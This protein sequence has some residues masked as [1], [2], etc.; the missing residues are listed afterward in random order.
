[1]REQRLKRFSEVVGRIVPDA[2][3]ASIVL[4][5]LLAG[6]AIAM[7]NSL[8]ATMD[9]YYRGLWMLL[10][11]TMQM[12]LIIVLSSTL[13]ATP[14]VRQMVIWLSRLPSSAFQVTALAALLGA[15]TSYLYWGL[16]MA[17]SPIAGVYFAREAERKGIKI[18]FPFLLALIWGANAAWQYGFSASAP[19]LVATPGHFLEKT[20]GLVPLSTTIGSPAAILHEV[21]FL[22]AIIVAG[23]WLMPK[24][25]REISQFPDSSRLADAAEEMKDASL[26]PSERWERNSL[27]ML[28]LC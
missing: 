16:G 3:T 7:G 14:A 15:V 21:L 8:A 5:L 22:A 9:A 23:Y 27:L 11:F 24:A 26:T 28:V 19:L 13:S 2:I 10:P 25:C 1:M 4:L 6:G 12:T 20:I 18:D 17:L